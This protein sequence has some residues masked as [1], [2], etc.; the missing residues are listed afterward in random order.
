MVVPDLPNS[1]PELGT[2]NSSLAASQRSGGGRGVG[3]REHRGQRRPDLSSAL[4]V[5]WRKPFPPGT[6][7]GAGCPGVHS[8]VPGPSL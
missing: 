2:C 1:W 5:G 7:Q 6:K 3:K 4:A 8:L